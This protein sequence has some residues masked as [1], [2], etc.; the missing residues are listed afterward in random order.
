MPTQALAWSTTSAW[1]NDRDYG[2]PECTD[3]LPH[4]A[5]A[6]EPGTGKTRVEMLV[7][8]GRHIAMMPRLIRAEGM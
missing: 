4:D 7:S 1:L 6:H 5:A 8:M 3:W 2:G